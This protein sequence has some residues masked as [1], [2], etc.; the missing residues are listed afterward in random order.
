MKKNKN[1]GFT[2]VELIITASI[3][4]IVIGGLVRLFM[5]TSVLGEIAGNK[6]T[7]ISEAQTKLEEIRNHDFQ[8]ISTDYAAGGTPGNIF[9]LTLLDGKGAIYIASTTPELLTIKIAISWK[10]KYNR[11]T[12]EDKN[13]DGILSLDEDVNSNGEFDSTVTLQSILTER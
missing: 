8:Q 1:D 12:G 6:T 13:L 10:N 9:N 5:F 11:I 7:A 2:L 3:L 4:A